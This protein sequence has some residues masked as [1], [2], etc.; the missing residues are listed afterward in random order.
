V[1]V[2]LGIQDKHD[3]WFQHALRLD[4]GGDVEGGGLA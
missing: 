1:D 4:P 2:L 3:A